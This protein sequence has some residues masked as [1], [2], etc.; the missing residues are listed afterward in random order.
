MGGDHKESEYFATCVCP[1]ARDWYANSIELNLFAMIDASEAVWSCEFERWRTNLTRF[2]H[3]FRS[4]AELEL[5]LEMM[6]S[7]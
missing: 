1:R 6:L 2:G 4:F 7:A 5:K 3:A